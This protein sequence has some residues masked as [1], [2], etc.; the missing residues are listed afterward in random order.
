MCIFAFENMYP[1]NTKE[2]MQ[3]CEQTKTSDS[4]RELFFGWFVH[5]KTQQIVL[6][7]Y[8]LVYVFFPGTIFPLVSFYQSAIFVAR[9]LGKGGC[10]Q[11][12][13]T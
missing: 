12:R 9:S 1:H 13:N 6:L 7:L 5:A 4:S 8:I 11:N 10:Y 3:V 2:A